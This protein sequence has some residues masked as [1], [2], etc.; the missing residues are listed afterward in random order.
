MAKSPKPADADPTPPEGEVS[1][2][3]ISHLIELRD[4]LLRAVIV[5]LVVLVALLPFANEIYAFLAA[6]LVA[7]MP[8]GAS[9]IATDVVTP[10]FAP[11]KLTLAVAVAIAIPVILYQ[12]WAF[13]AP[14]L[15]QNE[16]RM[17]LP[18][19]ISSTALFYIGMAFA[20]FVV[21]PTVF[22]FFVQ[23]APKGVLVMTDIRAYLDF[24][25]TMF[26]AFGVAFE[27]PVAVVLLA[28]LGVVNPATLA[29]KRPYVILGIFIIAA[30]LT[31]PDVL[32][33]TFLALPMWFLF[34][35]GLIVARRV[36]PPAETTDASG[37]DKPA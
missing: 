3:F 9:M 18:L 7:V 12:I 30:I 8:Q 37:D 27:V 34:E 36:A 11:I 20:Y 10:F 14:G 24:A 1:S 26:F 25:F 17:V 31:P 33:Q 6:P 22:E 13:V 5:V 29:N 16:K 32:S 2:T 19:V 15:Y 4:R 28:R 35:V 21:F 23:T